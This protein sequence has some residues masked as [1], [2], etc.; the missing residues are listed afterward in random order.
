MR[1]GFKCFVELLTIYLNSDVS[2]IGDPILFWQSI[3]TITTSFLL[4]GHVIMLDLSL[5]I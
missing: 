1:A 5:R 3:L 2:D 4:S